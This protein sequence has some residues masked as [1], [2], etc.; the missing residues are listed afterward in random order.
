M[1]LRRT[2]SSSQRIGAGKI[3]SIVRVTT[4]APSLGSQTKLAENA[5]IQLAILLYGN[6]AFV[7]SIR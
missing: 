4:V 3:I 2:G 7:T 1:R 6:G 5:D